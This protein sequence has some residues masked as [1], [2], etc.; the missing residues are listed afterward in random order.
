MAS[1]VLAVFLF[2]L[3]LLA[4]PIAKAAD[5]AV[6]LGDKGGV[7][8]EFATAFQQFSESSSW[9]VRWV[10][11]IDNLDGMPRADLIVAVGTEATRA[12]LRRGSTT[13]LVAT[14]L[15]RQAYERALADASGSRPRSA[16]T[17]VF[18]D[19]PISRQLAFAR[20]L[21]PDR[22]RIGVLTGPETRASLPQLKHTA[23]S[24][25]FSIESEEV[26]GETTLV[27]AL[28]QLLPRSDLLFAQPDSQV[29]RRDN[30]R[31]ILLTSYRF[32]RPVIGF[33]QAMVT[34]GALAA[35]YSTPSQMARQVADLVKPLH[36][37]SPSL[38]P[39]QPPATF[40]IAINANVAQALGLNI[41]DEPTIRRA[42]SGD[43]DVK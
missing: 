10:G 39:P 38:P 22:R 16:V 18:L 19:Q 36:P 43:K 26:E 5:V 17:A 11:T 3:S 15:P 4:A 25:G 8:G 6:V 41:P 29:Y 40:A 27:P 42:M 31:A 24:H 9:H 14:L 37:D 2:A 34:A 30:I 7:Y 35:I 1:R 13:P 33:S 21:L 12:S 23:A 32:Q 28:N 20:Q